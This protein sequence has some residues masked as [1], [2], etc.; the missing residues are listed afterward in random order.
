ME[1]QKRTLAKLLSGGF[2]KVIAGSSSATDWNWGGHDFPSLPGAKPS[3]YGSFSDLFRSFQLS[4]LQ[5]V[6]LFQAH[7]WDKDGH[8][9]PTTRR[10]S[11]VGVTKLCRAIRSVRRFGRPLAWRQWALWIPQLRIAQQ[12]ENIFLPFFTFVPGIGSVSVQKDS[13]WQF[14]ALLHILT[15]LKVG[16]TGTETHRLWTQFYFCLTEM[17]SI[18]AIGIWIHDIICNEK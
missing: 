16:G 8:E 11:E 7:A 9:A 14:H 18:R 10:F 4:E 17:Q 2:F 6:C 15:H 3:V 1:H 5:A 12:F 13:Y